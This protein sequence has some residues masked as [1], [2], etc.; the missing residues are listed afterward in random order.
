MFEG[1]KNRLKA[2]EKQA[3]KALTACV[4]IRDGT[5]KTLTTRGIYDALE[6]DGPGAIKNA[7]W[8]NYDRWRHGRA[9]E[10]VIPWI[11]NA[12]EKDLQDRSEAGLLAQLD[13]LA[14]ADSVRGK[15]HV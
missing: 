11:I 13:L 14:W 12:S 5:K 8:I 9:W 4:T 10:N 7:E 15:K 3:P 1:L 6:S 2:L